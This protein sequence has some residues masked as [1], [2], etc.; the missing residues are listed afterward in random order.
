MLNTSFRS[1]YTTSALIGIGLSLALV[2]VLVY[3]ANLS[4]SVQREKMARTD[5]RMQ[6]LVESI[7][8]IRMIKLF[9]W[10]TPKKE[11]IRKRRVTELKWLFKKK[12]G[13]TFIWL[14]VDVDVLGRSSI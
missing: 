11:H 13:K 6:S 8:L 2:P 14:E 7:G 5:A 1:D 9:S 4:R 3:A 12:V 10:E